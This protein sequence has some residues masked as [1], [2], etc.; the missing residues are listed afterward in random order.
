MKKTIAIIRV[1][2]NK[3]SDGLEIQRKRIVKYAKLNSFVVDTF[4]SEENVS[5]GNTNRHAIKELTELIERGEVGRLVVN[6][7][8]RMGRTLVENVML[9]DLCEKNNVIINTL[10]ENINTENSGGML[11]LK[12]YTIFAQEELKR[13]KERINRTIKHKKNRGVKYNGSLAYGLF[14]KNGLL[15]EDVYEMKQVR[16]MKNL[17]SRGYGFHLIAKRMNNNE[18]PTKQHGEKGWSYNQVKR[19]IDFHYNN[20]DVVDYVRASK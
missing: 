20:T 16:N 19:V 14:E 15:H 8:S 2:T 4:I 7:V 12:L 13:I 17:L 11:Q 3:Q 5:G 18:I 1:S 6:S 9:I 10:V